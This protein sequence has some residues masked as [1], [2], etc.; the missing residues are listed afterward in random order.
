MKKIVSTL[1][2]LLITIFSFA[3]KGKDGALT[4]SNTTIVNEFTALVSDANSGDTQLTLTQTT[5]NDNNRF[6]SALSSGDLILIIQMQ[7]AS[8]NASAEPWTGNGIYGLPL[9]AQW[10]EITNYNNCGNYEFAEIA[11]V[12]SS[13]VITLRCALQYNYTATGRVQIVR[14][15]RLTSLIVNDTLTTQ[16]WNG[17][18]GGICAIEVDGDIT[19]N[20]N[21]V[22]NATGLGFRGGLATLQN[23]IWGAGDFASINPTHGGMK[24]EGIA[25]YT[26]DYTPMGGQY[27]RGAAANAGGGSTSHNSGGGGGANAGDILNWQDGVGVPNPAYNTAWGLESPSIANVS[28]S[29]GGRGGYTFSSN[30]QNANT[31]APGNTAWGADNRRI[32][33]GFGGR[34]L[35][36]STNRLFFGGGGG[37]GELNNSENEG[38]NGGNAGGLIYIKCFGNIN[39]TGKI[40]SNGE[41]GED[42]FSNN[43]PFNSYAGN[44][45]AGGAGAGGTIKIEN[46]SGATISSLTINAT[47]GNGGNQQLVRGFFYVNS[48]NEAEGPGGGGGGGYV[49][50]PNNS[51]TINVNGGQNGTTNSQA[52]TEFPPNGATSGASGLSTI[53]NTVLNLSSSNDTICLGNTTTLVANLSNSLPSSSTIIWYD[54]DYNMIGTGVNF[55]TGTINNDTTFHVGICPGNQSIEVKV[56]IGASFSVD[57]SNL[58]I[59]NE[60]CDLNDGSIS[61]II[62]NGGA[63]PLSYS[64][65]GT[66]A[67]SL[68]T[69]NLSVGT[70]QLIVTDNDGCSS[71]IGTYTILNENGPTIDSTNFSLQHE[72]CDN[73]NG[74][75][76]GIT[77]AGGTAPYTTTWN[78]SPANIDLDNL[79]SGN[80]ML[81]VSDIYGCSDSSGIYTITNISGP[82]IDTSSILITPESCENNNGA[83][84]NITL[85][86]GTAPFNYVWS[87]NETTLDISNL[88]AGNYTLIVNDS[89]NCQD[90]ISISINGIGFPTAGFEISDSVYIVDEVITINNTSSSDVVS[91]NYNFDNNSTS[92]NNTPT[93]SYNSSGS[94]TICQ[95]VTNAYNCESQFCTQ[96][97]IIEQ[98]IPLVVPNV[99]TPNGDEQNEIFIIQ[100]S[101]N[102]TN[103]YVFD[104]WGNEVFHAAPYLNNWNGKHKNGQELSE[105]TYFYIIENKATNEELKGFF[106]LIR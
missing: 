21:G 63:L 69:T 94:Y 33:G 71:E 76:S 19:I 4:I 22:I 81:T 73:N 44:D 75:I 54:E 74:S 2:V 28:A 84:S 38:A 65:N 93:I 85:N 1:I 47:G 58:Q 62:I 56:I 10:G 18:T 43:P 101:T 64:W 61:G 78:S 80:Y 46:T 79:N 14:I 41:N 39:G 103:L 83:I 88:N 13:S 55:T 20:A 87:N 91:W 96:I 3:Q 99:F 98:N 9:S 60:H 53:S 12:N 86:N 40:E 51:A 5:L 77:I 25:G 82:S 48:I 102:E 97:T 57:T 49:S 90:S 29:G 26:S 72:A 104:R 17:S 11:S 32:Q 7:G 59:I 89:N 67:S 92:T 45:G 70:F 105:G 30:N 16:Q 24:G 66:T 35:D 95:N 52:L 37:S 42:V 68:D 36:Y 100:N 15:P 34:P 23:N 31:T 8:V 106:S 27:G 50:L 6:G